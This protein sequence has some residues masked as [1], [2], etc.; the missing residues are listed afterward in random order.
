MA[1]KKGGNPRSPSRT[2]ASRGRAVAPPRDEAPLLLFSE[3]E[4]KAVLLEEFHWQG[5]MVKD[6]VQRLR[7]R[8]ND[9][10]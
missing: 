3:K 8:K 7:R 4:L 9:E 1:V 5:P 2:R 6:L 10:S